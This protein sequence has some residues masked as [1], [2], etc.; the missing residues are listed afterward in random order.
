[1]V[2]ISINYKFIGNTSITSR[3][4]NYKKECLVRKNEANKRQEGILSK[5]ARERDGVILCHTFSLTLP[6]IAL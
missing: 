3:N 4:A 5:T 1:M 6:K 2:S